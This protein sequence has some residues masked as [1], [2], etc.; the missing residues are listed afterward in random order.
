MRE[1]MA[2]VIVERPRIRDR[3]AGRKGRARALEELPSCEGMRRPHLLSRHWK[4]LN[5]NLNPLRRFLERQVGRPWNKVYGE[6]ADR[7]RVDSTVQQHVRDH[8]GDFV[9]LDPRPRS[10]W[11]YVTGGG[12]ERVEYLW[13]QPLYVEPRDGIIKRTACHPFARALRR[14]EARRPIAPPDRIAL[15][16]GRELRRIAG[17]WYEAKLAPLPG[18]VDPRLPPAERFYVAK[19]RQLSRAE[20]RRHGLSNGAAAD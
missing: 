14:A 16:E 6:I 11:V 15:A 8:V 20:L 7:L 2:Q 1:D 9:A 12:K 4:M 17:I 5:E 13:Y 18:P 3:G 10:H 19:K